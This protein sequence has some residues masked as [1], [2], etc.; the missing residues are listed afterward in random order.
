MALWT[1]TSACSWFSCKGRLFLTVSSVKSKTKGIGVKY[2]LL[3]GDTWELSTKIELLP[4][5]L[6]PKSD[7]ECLQERLSFQTEL[8]R[9]EV[10]GTQ[11]MGQAHPYCNAHTGV[12]TDTGSY[13]K[14]LSVLTKGTCRMW[15]SIFAL[16]TSR[17]GPEGPSSRTP[18]HQSCHP[19]PPQ[20]KPMNCS[21]HDSIQAIAYL[22]FRFLCFWKK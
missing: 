16:L 8:S 9:C 22:R 6:L 15:V 11:P 20:R 17:Q 3:D 18:S 4:G 19:A 14:G 13:L 12:S 5:K 21:V 10:W 1:G 7:R 2:G